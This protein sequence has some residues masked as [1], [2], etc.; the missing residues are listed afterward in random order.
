[1]HM[2]GNFGQALWALPV[3]REGWAGA[4]GDNRGPSL[5]RRI[6]HLPSTLTIVF[7][8]FFL[9]L[10]IT[11][12]QPL[13]PVP[14]HHFNDYAGVISQPKQHELNERLAKFE[15]D[16]QNQV[17]VAIFPKMNS[18]LTL[19][20]YT[21]QIAKLWGVGQRGKNN[22]VIVFVF[23]SDHKMRIQVGYGLESVLTDELCK[24]IIDDDLKPHFRNSDF[25]GGL[26][27]GISSILGA[28][29]KQPTRERGDTK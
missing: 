23:I 20:E 25:E 1:M 10:G 2:P 9:V 29:S 5:L 26:A 3:G 4:L 24:R 17:V 15:K 11:Q 13:P 18:T 21:L 16:T 22:G 7:L 14:K 28:L 12:G 8:S 19:D 6:A 27:A